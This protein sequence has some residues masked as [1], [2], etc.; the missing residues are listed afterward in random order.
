MQRALPQ[1]Q[2][3]Q[4]LALHGAVISLGV[5]AE[6]LLRVLPV[7]LR[8]LDLELHSS[9]CSS[10]SLARLVHLT[11]LRVDGFQ[12][13]CQT[14]SSE[15]QQDEQQQQQQPAVGALRVLSMR[16]TSATSWFAPSSLE[17]LELIGSM[18]ATYASPMTVNLTQLGACRRLRHLNVLYD[19]CMPEAF[20]L[21]AL[22]QLTYLRLVSKGPPPVDTSRRVH[23]YSSSDSSSSSSSS[24]SDSSSSYYGSPRC[25]SSSIGSELAFL[26]QLRVLEVGSCILSA[27]QPQ[28]SWLPQLHHLTQLVVLVGMERDWCP[29]P[30]HQLAEVISAW[31]D[32]S[33]A[34]STAGTVLHPAPGGSGGSSGEGLQARP[35]KLR[36][37]KLVLLVQ[38]VGGW[39]GCS[40]GGLQEVAADMA[41]ALPWLQV[42]CEDDCYACPCWT[43]E[44]EVQ[45]G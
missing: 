17:T 28:H 15:G 11:S 13:E 3:L 41:A 27:T 34:S 12:L 30:L 36:C 26:R 43:V 40:W 35:C 18:G 42:V 23:L 8:A 44:S 32:S 4:K 2:Q 29:G 9:P 20:G 5:E 7:G 10:S 31:H 14:C 45:P 38:H 33:S 37:V 1:L 16:P 25:R 21:S 39:S 6:P 19:G 22:T 24:D